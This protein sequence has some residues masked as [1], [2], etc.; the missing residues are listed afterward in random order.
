MTIKDITLQPTP[1]DSQQNRS[2][3]TITLIVLGIE[4]QIR[5]SFEVTCLCLNIALK[6]C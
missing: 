2:E 4:Q 3:N 6:P 5:E 1:S